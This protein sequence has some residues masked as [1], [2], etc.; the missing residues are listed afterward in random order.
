MHL[1]ICSS[2]RS[3]DDAHICAKGAFIMA[4]NHVFDRISLWM[5][6][7]DV[8]LKNQTARFRYHLEYSVKHDGDAVSTDH[9]H[10][11]DIEMPIV[12]MLELCKNSIAIAFQNKV[13]RPLS[14]ENALK[15]Y[16]RGSVV[17]YDDVFPGRI[18]RKE[19]SKEDMLKALVDEFGVEGAIAKLNEMK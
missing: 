5:N 12:R 15:K 8:A 14:K 11:F 3:R 13:L 7:N 6:G 9:S 17:K 18:V 4:K 16:P 19:M 10:F 1:N 2:E